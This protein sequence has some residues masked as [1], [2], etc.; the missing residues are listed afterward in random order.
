MTALKEA[1]KKGITPDMIEG[2]SVTNQRETIVPV[3][4]DVEPLRRA[5]VWQDRRTISQCNQIKSN[6]GAWLC[7]RLG[8]TKPGE[9]GRCKRCLLLLPEADR[10]G[11][12]HMRN[13][14]L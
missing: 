9:G 8:H 4:K 14:R 6:I 13:V 5:I 7:K 1:A 11:D 3:D 10:S 12:R 2:I